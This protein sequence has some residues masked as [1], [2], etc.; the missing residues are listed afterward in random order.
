MELEGFKRAIEERRLGP[1]HVFMASFLAGLHSMGLLNQAV[2]TVAARRAGA[3]VALYVRVKE[4]LPPLEGDLPQRVKALLEYLQQL[5]PMAEGIHVE[6][7]G[8]RAEV[9]INR[10]RCK[11]C[12]KGVGE[13][14]LEGTL[15]P[16]PAL[17]EAF[18]N[19]LLEGAEVKLQLAGRYPLAKEGDDCKIVLELQGD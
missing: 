6:V 2:V 19:A 9:L 3:Q 5:M 4:E 16:Y 18:L 11:F 12:P 10:Q 17:L 8:R 13:A 1:W 7:A 14:E 15:C